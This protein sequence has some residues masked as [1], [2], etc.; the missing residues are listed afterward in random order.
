MKSPFSILLLSVVL[1]AKVTFGF[2]GSE[3]NLDFS[4][5]KV[6]T[7]KNHTISVGEERLILDETEPDKTGQEEKDSVDSIISVIHYFNLKAIG[8]KHVSASPYQSTVA[9]CDVAI[10]LKDRNF[11]I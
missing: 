9:L 5:A 1:L 4:K 8:S 10:Y 6:F 11:R 7:Q 2:Y 3:T